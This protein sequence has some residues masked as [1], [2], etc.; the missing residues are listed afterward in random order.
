MATPTGS[1]TLDAY[2]KEIALDDGTVVVVRPL[3]SEDGDALVRFFQGIPEDDR[4]YLKED[5][6]DPEVVRRWVREL[7][8]G[9][10]FPLVAWRD[11]EIVAD[12]TLHRRGWG[13]RRHLG[14]LRI[15]VA[16]RARRKGLG[17]ALLAELVDVASGLG[18]ERL[19]TEVISGVE[20]PAF[21]VVQQVGFERV[22]LIP[23][24]LKGRDGQP[25]DLII[26]I[27]PLTE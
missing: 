27:M 11:G 12:A 21:E 6:G 15:V 20:M 25:H 9:R 3:G 17:I 23:D 2:P 7:D 5:V 22:A 8:Y 13:A 18:L 1:P 16:P 24:H 26:L 19:E 4:Y 10:V 14:E